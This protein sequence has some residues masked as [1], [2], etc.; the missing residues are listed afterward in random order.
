MIRIFMHV[1]LGQRRTYKQNVPSPQPAAVNPASNRLPQSAQPSSISFTRIHSS[2]SSS[3]S[4]RPPVGKITIRIAFVHT[5]RIRGRNVYTFECLCISLDVYMHTRAEAKR[6]RNVQLGNTH[7]RCCSVAEVAVGCVT[8]YMYDDD[9][10]DLDSICN[11][12][13]RTHG[14]GR[15]RCT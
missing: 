14:K 10:A 6:T 7:A 11:R 8:V 12:E 9:D 1:S 4:S 3:S 5:I 13:H 15:G 2:L